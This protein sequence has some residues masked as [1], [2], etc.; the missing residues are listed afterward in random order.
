[1]GK[2]TIAKPRARS[3]RGKISRAGVRAGNYTRR[4][5]AP[6]RPRRCLFA[7]KHRPVYTRAGVK[8]PCLIDDPARR[9]AHSSIGSIDQV[10][11]AN[12][13]DLPGRPPGRRGPRTR[14]GGLASSLVRVRPSDLALAG[15][16]GARP[17]PGRGLAGAR[18]TP[19][20][21]LAGARPTPLRRVRVTDSRDRLGLADHVNAGRVT[22]DGP[23]GGV[24]ELERGEKKD[25]PTPRQEYSELHRTIDN[26]DVV[27]P[28][29]CPSVLSLMCLSLCF[30]P[31]FIP[32]FCP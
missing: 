23:G 28:Y 5:T 15:L 13:L 29:V 20:R 21:G 22:A 14:P 12:R 4:C 30:V 9:P 27:C 11:P 18:P 2:L 7:G 32:L 19:G 24:Y 8:Q 3:F 26:H 17:T 16:A 31:M 25:I 6:L 1:L 10:G